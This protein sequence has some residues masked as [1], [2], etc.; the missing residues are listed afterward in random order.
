[1]VS[2]CNVCD[3]TDFSINAGFYYCDNCG[4][5][6]TVLQEI[7]SQ[8]FATDPFNESVKIQ[9]HKIKG[10]EEKAKSKCRSI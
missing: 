5:R 9:K 10:K 6:I 1:M 3:G 4:N 8:T 2:I 7:E